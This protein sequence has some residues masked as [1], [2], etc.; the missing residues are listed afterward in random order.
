MN[1][2]QSKGMKLQLT[3]KDEA[4]EAPKLWI[5]PEITDFYDFT[6]DD[7]KLID[8]NDFEISFDF[9]EQQ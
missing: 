1:F 6:E 7:I 3:R 5:N 2:L 9:E 8:Y 4:Y